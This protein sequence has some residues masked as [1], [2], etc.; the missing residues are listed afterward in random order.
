LKY[1]KAREGDF[2][3]T[4]EGLIFDV[5]GLIHPP[6]RVVAYLRYFED[7]VGDRKRGEK[8]YRKVYSLSERDNFISSKYPNYI[9]FDPNFGERIEGVPE[10]SIS[11]HHK[12]S[13]KVLELNNK[14]NLD[15]LQTKA[16]DFIHLISDLTNIKHE[17]MGITGSILVNLHKDKSDLDVIF[18]G[19]KN[20]FYIRNT[21]SNLLKE[22][23]HEVHP[24]KPEDLKQLYA[25]RS[26]DTY[27][28]FED[29]FR[30]EKRKYMQGKFK[31]TDFFVRYLLDWDENKEKYGDYKYSPYGYAKIKANITDDRESIFTPCK[32]LVSEVKVLKGK[33][34]LPVK[35]ITSFRGRFC[36]QAKKGEQI[37]A[38]GKVEKVIKADDGKEH[39]RL[40]LGGKPTDFMKNKSV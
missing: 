13:R 25:F 32:Y 17:N 28:P 19:K 7:P 37:I 18:Y 11:K 29:F 31:K 2:I 35:E 34:T 38:Q 3:E 21:L 26:K 14:S 4:L 20:C 1:L 33:K 40:V 36:E 12:P 27:M 22:A 15:N 6:N 24:Y 30:I 10:K 8:S 9:F 16:L 23:K 5:K 39:F